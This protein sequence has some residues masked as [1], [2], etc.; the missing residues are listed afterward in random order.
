MSISIIHQST[1]KAR[2]IYN[3]D[4]CNFLF[5]E[6]DVRQLGLTFTEYRAVIKARKCGYRIMKGQTYIRQFNADTS[7]NSW[8]YR[9]IPEIHNI[10]VRLELYGEI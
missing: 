9:A 4:A 2:K 5:N 8:T 1:P 3:C 6:E 10:C 7:G